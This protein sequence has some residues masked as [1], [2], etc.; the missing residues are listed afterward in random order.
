MWCA[1]WN[2]AYEAE[3]VT[4]SIPEDGTGYQVN[5]S[6]SLSLDSYT[7]YTSAPNVYFP[8]KSK[9]SDGTYGY[10]LAGPSSSKSGYLMH[11]FYSGRVGASNYNR[12]YLG[13]RPLVYLP[14]S[15][16]LEPSGT[17]NVWNINYGD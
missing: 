13:V 5:G 6:N 12:N 15:V 14:S 7:G 1:S 16:K 11:V 2:K 4:P 10:W 9:D 3:K 17:P 8:T